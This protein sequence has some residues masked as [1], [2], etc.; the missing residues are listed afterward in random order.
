MSTNST[1]LDRRSFLKASA[2]A[3]GGLMIGF[4]WFAGCE[5]SGPPPMKG[6]PDQWFDVNAFLREHYGVE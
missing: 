5:P 4:N 2:L 6:P 1:D 3:G